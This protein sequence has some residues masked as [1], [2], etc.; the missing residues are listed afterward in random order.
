MPSCQTS[1]SF[2]NGNIKYDSLLTIANL[3]KY[4]SLSYV[5]IFICWQLPYMRNGYKFPCK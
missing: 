2:D 5:T 4:D 1:F 3:S